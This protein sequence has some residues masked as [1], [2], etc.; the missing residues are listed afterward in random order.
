[1][2]LIFIPVLKQRNQWKQNKGTLAVDLYNAKAVDGL[3]ETI[4][5]KLVPIRKQ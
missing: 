1:M 4:E 2:A 3:N 5:I